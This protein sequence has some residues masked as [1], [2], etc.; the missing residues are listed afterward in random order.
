[1]S[2]AAFAASNS[3][4]SG[5][6]GSTFDM[7]IGGRAG[8]FLLRLNYAGTWWTND[9]STLTRT[10]EKMSLP[11]AQNGESAGPFSVAEHVLLPRAQKAAKVEDLRLREVVVGGDFAKPNERVGT[12]SRQDGVRWKVSTTPPHGYRSTVQWSESLK[13]WI[14]AGTNGSDIS[15]DDG[16]T[17]QPLDNGNWNAL[18][19]PF[20]VGPNGRIG[21]LNPTS[22]PKP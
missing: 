21:R 2:P 12:A 19:L 17:W 13:L 14:T 1:M 15:R 6:G 11:M 18:S 22:I 10:W 9:G 5:F 4:I 8:S 16:R 3:C 20:L 7:V